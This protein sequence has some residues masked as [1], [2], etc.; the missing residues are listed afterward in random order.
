MS[1]TD[2]IIIISTALFASTFGAYAIIRVVKKHTRPIQNVLVRPNRD[3]ELTDYIEPIQENSLDLLASPEPTYQ[4]ILNYENY[5]R[6]PSFSSGN[7][8]SY[9]TIDRWYINS[10]LENNINLDFILWL[11]LFF[12]LVF[13]IFI[14]IRKLI[15]SNKLIVNIISIILIFF[16]L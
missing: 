11:I 5:E 14:L 1:Q 4:R 10:Y 2:I 6:V 13:I 7:P 15:I 3:I 12:I 9:H 16:I 8:P